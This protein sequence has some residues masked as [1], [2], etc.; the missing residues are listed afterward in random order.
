M[1]SEPPNNRMLQQQNVNGHGLR[2][3]ILLKDIPPSIKFAHVN[4]MK[5]KNT[6]VYELS[7]SLTT[8]YVY[9]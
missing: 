6:S 9:G 8:S 1:I 7:L 4:C 3:T 5:Q 2:A